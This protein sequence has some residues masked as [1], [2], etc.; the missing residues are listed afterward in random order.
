MRTAVIVAAGMS[1]RLNGIAGDIPK[2]FIEI[3]GR[4]LIEQS[5]AKL[6]RAGIERIVIGTGY[7]HEHFDNLARR[8]TG[9]TCVPNAHF[10]TSGSM[11]TLYRLKT[12]IREDFLLL[13]SDL[14][15]DEKGLSALVADTGK[16]VVLASGAT[17]SGDEVF[18]ETDC[19]GRLVNVSKNKRDLGSV[20]GE[21][22]GI[23]KVSLET[24]RGMCRFAERAF[25]NDRMLDYEYAL[26]GVAARRP[27]YVKKIEGYVW[28]EI[29][30]EHHLHRAI[31][32]IYPQLQ[33]DDTLGD[34]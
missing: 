21:L 32:H 23:T 19:R 30:D 33:K 15:Y 17:H 24:Y 5:I 16:D 28:C 13:E 7:R 22:V 8:D 10:E 6:R 25:Q 2:G 29:D 3:G 18:I 4:T 14:L 20:Y 34:N 1:N 12:A 26:V 11:Y 27:L 31:N 9:I